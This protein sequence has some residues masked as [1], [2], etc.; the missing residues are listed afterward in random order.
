MRCSVG[1]FRLFG[2][3]YACEFTEGINFDTFH[4]PPKALL[5]INDYYYGSCCCCCC[6][7]DAC[8]WSN[9]DRVVRKI[10]FSVPLSFGCDFCSDAVH[11]PIVRSA[12][13]YCSL[14][15]HWR[16]NEWEGTRETSVHC[17]HCTRSPVIDMLSYGQRCHSQLN[18]LAACMLACMQ[19]Q[20]RICA[21]KRNPD[22]YYP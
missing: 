8:V 6:C 20:Q 21:F 1:R 4:N 3:Q 17:V 15:T 7:Y 9:W 18:E 2:M 5:Y 16:T 19:Q 11:A 13:D 12:K 10:Y 14:E 22:K